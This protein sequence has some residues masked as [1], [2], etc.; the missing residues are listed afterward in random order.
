[1]FTFAL[2]ALS[3]G[4]EHRVLAILERSGDRKGYGQFFGDL[5]SLGANISYTVCGS[6][7][8]ELE[9]F[10]EKQYD[11]VVIMCGK[12][13]CF[14]HNA[15]DLTR[16]LDTG[17]NG[18][19]FM[20]SVDNTEIQEKLYRHFGLRV[21]SSH[22]ITDVTG[23]D[24]V[25]LRNFLAPGPVVSKHPNPLVYEGGF[26][27]IDRPN[28]FRIPIV[29]GGLEHQLAKADRVI[30]A[31]VVGRDIVPIYALQARS[32]GR[33]VIIHSSTF[34]RDETFALPVAKDASLAQIVPGIPN[35]NRALLKEL[36]EY[37][38]HYKSHVRIVSANH[39]DAVSK[40]APVQY[41]WK[42][43]ITVVAEL[44]TVEKGE[45]VPYQELDVQVEIF[46]LGVFVRRHMKKIAPGKYQETLTLP[47]RA[48]NFKVKVFTAKDGWMNAR[49]EMAIAVRP[50]AI[51]EKEK[52][53]FCAQP[54][55]V[56]V[57]LVMAAAFLAS[58]HF[59]W[60]KPSH[61]KT[62]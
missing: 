49:E 50:L 22:R 15:E 4:R 8:L 53:L 6:E 52:F 35:G 5:E 34:A 20:P 61:P 38:T 47:D 28:D 55:Q 21:T 43:N 48:G 16:Y 33:F 57:I 1:M 18:F 54:Y 3:F 7:V 45:W 27:T 26:G 19:L 13:A 12:A 32:S 39:Y 36:S 2:L 56:S 30:S 60:H 25:V 41:H 42:Q 14:G 51:R 59:L 17:G 9:R 40:E 23:A 10:G 37:V 31:P 44:E 46:M 29:T 11:S 62:E 58:V 24:Y